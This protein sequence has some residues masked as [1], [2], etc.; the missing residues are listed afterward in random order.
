MNA[1]GADGSDVLA[2]VVADGAHESQQGPVVQTWQ[3]VAGK[4]CTWRY[5]L[6]RTFVSSLECSSVW[7]VCEP[8]SRLNSTHMRRMGW[9]VFSGLETPCRLTEGGVTP[10]GSCSPRLM[11]GLSRGRF[12]PPDSSLR[13]K[14][15][16]ER[17][18]ATSEVRRS[19]LSQK[20]W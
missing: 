20:V 10:T 4:R 16:K 3:R 7:V 12:A 2:L 6:R 11:G 5:E 1:A 17:T 9:S 19:P 8:T 15:D 13:R 18:R 14:S